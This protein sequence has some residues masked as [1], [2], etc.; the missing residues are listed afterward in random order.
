MPIIKPILQEPFIPQNYTSSPEVIKN[1]LQEVIEN[2]TLKP[3]VSAPANDEDMTKKQREDILKKHMEQYTTKY[4][5]QITGGILFC[6]IKPTH[7]R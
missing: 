2:S 6:R 3:Q 1:C 4:M 7:A 5:S